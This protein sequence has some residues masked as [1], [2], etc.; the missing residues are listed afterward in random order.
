MLLSNRKFDLIGSS[1][2][3]FESGLAEAGINVGYYRKEKSIGNK[4]IRFLDHPEDNRFSLVDF[5]TIGKG[6]QEKL[7]T[8]F[9]NPYEFVTKDPIRKMVQ[10]SIV[11]ENFYLG[12]EFENGEKLPPEYV[13]KY[14]KCADWMNMLLEVENDKSIVKKGLKIPLTTF[15]THVM[16]I[17]KSDNIDLPKTYPYLREKL[18]KFKTGGLD[19][20]IEKWRFNNNHAAK[21]NDELSRSVLLELI[22]DDGKQDDLMIARAYNRWAKANNYKEIRDWVVGEWRR[23]NEVDILGY[24]DGNAAWYN[25]YGKQLVRNRP[26]A[27]LLL[28]GGDGNDWDMFFKSNRT[29]K[30]GGTEIYYFNKFT[31]CIVIDAF[32]DYPLGWAISE[33]NGNENVELI[34]AAYKDALQHIKELTGNYYL[35]NQIQN[36]RFGHLQILE[37]MQKMDPKFFFA[38]ARAPRGKY[39]ERSFGTRWHQVLRQYKNYSGNNI[40]AVTKINPQRIDREKSNF[41]DV[42]EA[43]Y[44]AQNFITQLRETVAN[45]ET[46]ETKAQQWLTAFESSDKSKEKQITTVQFLYNFGTLNTRT[47]TITNKGLNLQIDNVLYAFEIPDKFYLSTVGKTVQVIYDPY[48]FSR[49]LITDN[50]KLR[51]LA[52]P[53]TKLPGAKADELP[54]DEAKFFKRLHQ[55]KLHLESITAKKK[56]RESVLMESGV[57]ARAILQAGVLDKNIKHTA[58]LQLDNDRSNTSM[59]EFDIDPLEQM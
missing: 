14:C 17:F 28:I 4:R 53:P 21:V 3:V 8:K 23:K 1:L 35:P 50:D 11:T 43:F 18:L 10:K 25:K 5:E 19:S 2:Y 13:D 46:G 44:Y 54:G 26:S 56:N 58:M 49:V 45:K 15:Y 55:K 38:A 20:L 59:Q 16:D 42:S 52:M 33:P 36:D 22:S 39:I 30:T 32:N 34:K 48:D 40:N 29:S 31:L 57:S 41:P 47:Q 6:H 27:P 9:G 37:F 51:F 7:K 24:R 12:F